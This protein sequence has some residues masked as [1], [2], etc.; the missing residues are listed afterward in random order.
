MSIHSISV[1]PSN[2]KQLVI[3]ITSLSD[4][5]RINVGTDA[6]G[7]WLTISDW[8]EDATIYSALQAFNPSLASGSSPTLTLRLVNL[9]SVNVDFLV[10]IPA[11]GSIS[12]SSTITTIA[13]YNLGF[14][15]DQVTLN[16]SDT[17]K[18][19][20]VSQSSNAWFLE[21]QTNSSVWT[22]LSPV[23]KENLIGLMTTSCGQKLSDQG[24][25]AWFSASNGDDFF[26]FV[27]SSKISSTTKA[28]M[29][30][31]EH[32]VDGFRRWGRHGGGVTLLGRYSSSSQ[33]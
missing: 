20:Y 15:V 23:E 8:K 30:Q 18:I 6:Q 27:T 9:A 10:I 26:D 7:E 4:A 17:I 16:D 14:S 32:C 5:N 12:S 19:G 31:Y 11:T 1:R 24:H 29:Q 21:S 25:F 22:G 2:T 13:E 28:L 33:G 3:Q